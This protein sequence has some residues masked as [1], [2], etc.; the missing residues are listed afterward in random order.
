MS[1]GILLLSFCYDMSLLKRSNA[2]CNTM[3]GDK[4]FSFSMNGSMARSFTPGKMNSYLECL[5]QLEQN[6]ALC[7]MEAV[8]RCHQ[9]AT[10]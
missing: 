3:M 10:R 9:P 2:V 5:F 8:H 1:T 7:L 4:V 6:S